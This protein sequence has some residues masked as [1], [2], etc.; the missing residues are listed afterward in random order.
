MGEQV[1]YFINAYKHD[2][3]HLW[4]YIHRKGMRESEDE[5]ELYSE[6]QRFDHVG[7]RDSYIEISE[8]E[9]MELGEL[10][11]SDEMMDKY[12]EKAMQIISL[13]KH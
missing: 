5:I 7:S 10:V 4:V 9:Y 2:E 3:D 12:F 11:G 6:F 8:K 13:K 1:R